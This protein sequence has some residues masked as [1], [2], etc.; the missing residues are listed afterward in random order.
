MRC[1]AAAVYRCGKNKSRRA[2]L[3]RS[4]DH[5]DCLLR[6]V[7]CLRVDIDRYP[8]KAMCVEIFAAAMKGALGT[9]LRRRPQFLREFNLLT[10]GYGQ[11]IVVYSCTMKV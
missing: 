10:I 9:W 3:Y 11:V 4:L 2:G 1:C 5:F 7:D 8:R 6:Y